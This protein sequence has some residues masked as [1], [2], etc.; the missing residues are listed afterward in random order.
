MDKLIKMSPL[1]MLKMF[2]KIFLKT[3]LN[4]KMFSKNNLIFLL[5]IIDNLIKICSLKT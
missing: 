1:K 2:L 5:Y 4:C 3:F